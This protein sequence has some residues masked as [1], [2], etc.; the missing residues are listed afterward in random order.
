ML[1]LESELKKVADEDLKERRNKAKQEKDDKNKSIIKK[2][3]EWV[4]HIEKSGAF[5]ELTTDLD[6]SATK[7][8]IELLE[9][10]VNNWE[11]I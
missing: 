3:K 7:N 4:G 10:C 9:K 6:K 2:I 5:Q 11:E 8:L 1:Q